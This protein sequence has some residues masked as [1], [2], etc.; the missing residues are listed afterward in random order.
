ML[1]THY[2]SI[3]FISQPGLT[4]EVFMLKLDLIAF[5]K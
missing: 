3:A 5:Q 2:F 4:G 1:K